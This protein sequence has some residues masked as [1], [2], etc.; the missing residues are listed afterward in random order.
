MNASKGKKDGAAAQHGN[1]LL[2]GSFYNNPFVGLFIRASDERVAVPRN[3]PQKTLEA[4]QNAL[5]API[6]SASVSQSNLLGIFS[7]MNSNGAVLSSLAEKQEA[8]EFKKQGLNVELLEPFSPG[9][10]L[11]VNNKAALASHHLSKQEVKRVGDCLGVEVFQHRFAT[12]SVITS[13]VVTNKGFVAHNDL[14]ETELK[15]LEKMFG[16]PGMQATVNGG[17]VCSSLGLVAN[18]RGALVG[19]ATSGFEVQR[20]FE[21]LFG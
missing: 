16:V 5:G 1:H 15:L 20:I 14:T 11:A 12:P 18:S 7:V 10:N 9:C 19:E 13:M 8:S 17:T 21:A 6:F 3:I 4:V 2:K